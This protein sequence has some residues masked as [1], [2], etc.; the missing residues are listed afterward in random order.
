MTKEQK[1]RPHV[2]LQIV[3]RIKF[4]LIVGFG[5]FYGGN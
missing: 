1:S 3:M 4:Y 2:D 5:K